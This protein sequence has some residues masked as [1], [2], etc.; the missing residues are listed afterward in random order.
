MIA[1]VTFEHPVI[2]GSPA[3]LEAATGNIADAVGLGAAIDYVDRIVIENSER[4]EH[5]LLAYATY[6]STTCPACG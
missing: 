5:D 1:D 4:Y 6:Q 3:L 2:H